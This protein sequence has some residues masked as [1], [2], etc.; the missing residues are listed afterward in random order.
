MSKARVWVES[1]VTNTAVCADFIAWAKE[2]HD[3]LGAEL[4]K[5]VREGK[6]EESAAIAGEMA[7]YHN[8]R[9]KIEGEMRERE[10]QARYNDTTKGG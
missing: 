5:T 9:I 2:A 1:I 8:L 10:A 4:A 7:A 3:T 6:H